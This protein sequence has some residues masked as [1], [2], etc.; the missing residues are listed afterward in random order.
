MGNL[1]DVSKPFAEKFGKVIFYVIAAALIIN[2]VYSASIVGID[3]SYSSYNET[4]NVG[5]FFAELFFTAPWTF[6]QIGL[7]RLFV[8][9]VINS[10]KKN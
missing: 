10:G 9:L 1:F 8:E 6:A 3:R 2:W 5:R 4:F 7:I